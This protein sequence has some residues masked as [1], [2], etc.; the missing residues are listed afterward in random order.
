MAREQAPVKMA[1]LDDYQN[2]ALSMADWSVLGP[3]TTV[4]VFKDHLTDP[5]AI[6]ARGMRERTPMTRAVIERLTLPQ[7]N[8][9]RDGPPSRSRKQH[10]R[11]SRHRCVRSGAPGSRSSLPALAEVGGDT[12]S[13]SFSRGLYKRFYEDTVKNSAQ[14]LA[15]QGS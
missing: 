6:I 2:L 3:R 14:W 11:W 10:D 13:V 9:D 7:P 8:C 4:S 15:S 12:P 1:V 5:E